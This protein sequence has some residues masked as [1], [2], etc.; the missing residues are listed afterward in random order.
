MV[1]AMDRDSKLS[2]RWLAVGLLM[3]TGSVDLGCSRLQSRRRAETPPML[4]MQTTSRDIYAEAHRARSETPSPR[5]EPGS[6]IDVD[7][8]PVL[9]EGAREVGMAIRPAASDPS[10]V[11]LQPP[12]PM[13]VDAPTASRAASTTTGV[14]NSSIL[15]AS[16][17][18][19][20]DPTLPSVT[21]DRLVTE[22]RSAL[23]RIAS[24][25][26]LMHRQERVNGTLQPEEDVVLAVR[27][28][29]RSVRLSWPNG[30]HK[31]REVLYR[32]DEPG[33]LM[34]VNMA[35]SALPIPRLSIPPDSPMVMKNSRHPITEA[36]FDSLIQ[37]L[38][39]PQGAPAGSKL[40]YIGLETP[41]PLDHPHHGLVRTGPSGEVSRIYL[42][43][44]TY[45]PMLFA[46]DGPDGELL[47]RYVFRDVVV[48]PPDLAAANA[49]D[50]NARWGPPR[51]LFGRI[52]GGPD[53]PADSTPR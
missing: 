43:P 47:E 49:F 13:S 14:P 23:D 31:G 52:A 20:T 4:G 18:R 2:A 36:G 42:D 32:A 25:R 26:V 27:R 40:S 38:E 29:P 28:E 11:R 17:E 16:T 45:L 1:P 50:P 46:V 48:N 34:H 44:K 12:V 24:Y 21:A 8:S 5:K 19:P 37:G 53:R 10:G 22:A 9:A 39:G 7:E 51:G 6:S 30:P 33:G 3:V 15:L 41:A 35:D